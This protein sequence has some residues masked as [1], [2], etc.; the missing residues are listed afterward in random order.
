MHA[1]DWLAPASLQPSSATVGVCVTVPARRCSVRSQR[2]GERPTARCTG[3]A[4]GT[5][6]RQQQRHSVG[7][8][9]QQV[10][11]YTATGGQQAPRVGCRAAATLAPGDRV[12]AVASW[13]NK[14]IVIISEDSRFPAPEPSP[15]PQSRQIDPE[16]G[17]QSVHDSVGVPCSAELRLGGAMW[18][19]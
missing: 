5:T 15:P 10:I 17:R 1:L 19:D 18:R 13:Q 2:L 7:R 11:N 16:S 3:R 9:R 12:D 6:S 8:L 14:P 4:R